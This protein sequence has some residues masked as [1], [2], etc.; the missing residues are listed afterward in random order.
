MF[1]KRGALRNPLANGEPSPGANPVFDIMAKPPGPAAVSGPAAARSNAAIE[2]ANTPAIARSRRSESYYDI[3]SSIFNALIDAID[4]TQLGQLDRDGARRDPRH[5][6]RDHHAQGC[7][8]VDRRAGGAARGHLQRRSRLR[9]ARAAAG[10]RRH[11][12]HHDQRC[13]D[14]LHRGK[15]PDGGGQHPLRDARS[16]SVGQRIVS[17]INAASTR[18]ASICDARLPD[19]HAS[20]S[21][22]RRCRSTAR[23]SPSASS[24]ATARKMADLWA[25]A[26]SPPKVQPSRHHRPGPLQRVDLRHHRARRRCSTA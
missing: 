15:W 21:S 23:P 6:Q 24:A 22:C 5:R 12:R 18:R 4:L 19:G 8:D 1:G 26:R 16:C 9:P 3:K 11:R 7:R 17:Q 2:A 20:T 13:Q 14:L 25:S 10:A